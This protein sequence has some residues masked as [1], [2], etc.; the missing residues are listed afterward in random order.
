ML[1][2]IRLAEG[3]CR[4]P[5]QTLVGNY[6]LLIIVLFVEGVEWVPYTLIGRSSGVTL[7]NC[8]CRFSHKYSNYGFAANGSGV[9]LSVL[10][11]KLSMSEASKA[12]FN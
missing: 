9:S 5:N 11:G 10:L 7:L 1:P 3:F 4:G 6:W 8:S 2:N 12:G